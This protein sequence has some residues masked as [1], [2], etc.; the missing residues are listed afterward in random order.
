MT[1]DS[2]GYENCK[3][4]DSKVVIYKWQ[5]TSLALRV[6]VLKR[7][8]WVISIFW[9]NY[10]KMSIR[11]YGFIF[12][13]G[14]EV[15]GKASKCAVCISCPLEYV[16]AVQ[17]TTSCYETFRIIEKHKSFHF[18]FPS[19]GGFF[20]ILPPSS[21]LSGKPQCSSEFFIVR[22]WVPVSVTRLGD[23]LDFG[24]FFK[25]CVNN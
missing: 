11:R 17:L 15:M 10:I 2:Y 13:C 7:S 6:T 21:Y 24:H 20:V 23:L 5:L 22:L 3:R 14:P 4:N 1:L 18:Y 9:P 19:L 12:N 25:A 8:D 16:H